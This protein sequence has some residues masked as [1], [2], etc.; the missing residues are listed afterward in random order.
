MA[1]GAVNSQSQAT[2]LRS[3]ETVSS[4]RNAIAS[5]NAKVY[6]HMVPGA[7]FVMPDGLEVRFLG[8]VFATEDAAIIAELDKVCNK[9][10]SQIYTKTEAKEAAEALQKLAAEDASKQQGTVAPSA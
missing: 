1:V 7:R 2:V 4:S 6:H 10:T 9:P 3:G 8:G 5:K